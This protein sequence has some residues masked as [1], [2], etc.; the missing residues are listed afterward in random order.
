MIKYPLLSRIRRASLLAT[1]ACLLCAP[2][3]ASAYAFRV[4]VFSKSVSYW[5]ESI[6]A[7]IAAIQELGAAHDFEV[8][9]TEDAAQFTPANLTQFAVVVFLLN[10]GDVLDAA[11]EAA[12]EQF[13]RAGGGWVGVHTAADTE[14]GWPWYGQLV[15]A[16]FRSEPPVQQGTVLVLDRAHPA[17]SALPER[18]VLTEEW[19]NFHTNPRGSVHVLATIDESTVPGTDMGHDH[20]ISW[21]HDFDGG[22]AFFTGMGHTI[23]AY[24]DPLFRAHLLGGIQWAAGQAPGDAG[25][26]VNA[27]FEKIVPGWSGERSDGA[28]GRSGR[29]RVFHRA[30]R[31]G[32]NL[33]ASH[34]DDDGCGNTHAG[35]HRSR[36]RPSSV[37]RSIR[38]SRRTAGSISSTR[39][40]A[41]CRK[42]CCR[43]SPSPVARWCRAPSGCCC[44]SRRIEASAC[45]TAAASSCRPGR[46]SA[47]RHR[48]QYLS[49]RCRWLCT[50]R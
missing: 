45:T 30:R 11:Q 42:M 34:A 16:R 41:S 8:V 36:R 21:C 50:D 49:R 1:I 48:R 40:R 43:V 15:G 31:E 33:L 13:I 2:L 37:W 20:P 6:P 26:T 47:D 12:F 28:G 4:L 35:P 44:A 17:T 19:F 23:A 24:A 22:R 27:S 9:A 14:Y 3:P 32:E 5:H 25:A 29:A 7:G 39:R 10:S 18:W 46:Q 38:H